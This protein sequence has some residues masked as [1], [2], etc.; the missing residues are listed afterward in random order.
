MSTVFLP[1]VFSPTSSLQC[2]DTE[3]K[4]TYRIFMTEATKSV[5][6]LRG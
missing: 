6:A 3:E 5:A 4:K 2:L 1:N